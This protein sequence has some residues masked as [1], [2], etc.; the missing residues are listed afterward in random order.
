[1]SGSGKTTIGK[2]L[3]QKMEVAFRDADDYH[4]KE[5]IDKMAAGQPL[6]DNDRQGWL[7]RL[8]ELIIESQTDGLVLACSALKENYRRI[9]AS[10]LHKDIKWIYLDG[11]FEEILARMKDRKDHF[12]PSELLRSQFDTLEIPSYA[13]SVPINTSPEQTVAEIVE[14]LG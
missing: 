14:R 13:L 1:V 6:N 8:N 4:P 12:M 7:E 3:A 10:G 2:L 5:N 11:S 9:L